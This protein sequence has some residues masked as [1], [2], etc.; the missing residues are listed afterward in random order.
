M[1]RAVTV[2]VIVLVIA[3]GIYLIFG[4]HGGAPA[5][6]S[7]ESSNATITT[8]GG[9]AKTTV[10]DTKTGPKQD[11]TLPKEDPQ[12]PTVKAYLQYKT[13]LRDGK[14]YEAREALAAA[15]K[16]TFSPEQQQAMTADMKAI[17]ERLIFSTQELRDAELYT[18]QSGDNPTKIAKKYNTEAEQVMFI[19]Q[20][21]S[22]RLQPGQ[23]LKVLKGKFS[24]RVIKSRFLLQLIYQDTVFREYGVGIGRENK[25]PVGTFTIVLKIKKPDWYKTDEFG[26]KTKIEYGKPGNV[27]GERWM[28]FD[29]DS[30]GIHG[31]TQPDSIGKAVSDGCVR[32]HNEQVIELYTIVPTGTLVTIVD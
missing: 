7:P 13:M 20:M 4:S 14:D 6:T 3:G 15:S 9:D 11:P 10:T 26:R 17:N 16:G 31:T 1:N 23:K 24:I 22:D 18:V 19:N 2:L 21:K 30:Y 25:T 28:G 12:D 5:T 32:M 8:E 27:L 29:K